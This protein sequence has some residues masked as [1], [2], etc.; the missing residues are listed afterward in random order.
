MLA[1][2]FMN[3][4]WRGCLLASMVLLSNVTAALA[5][6]PAIFKQLAGSWR[7]SG[8]LTLSDGTRD[9]ISCRGYYRLTGNGMSLA[10]LCDSPNYKIEIRSNLVGGGNGISGHWEERTFNANGELSGRAS[11]NRMRLSITGYINGSMSVSLSG[12]RQSVSISAQ[13]TGF[14]SV[15]MTLVPG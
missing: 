14:K 4:A 5:D 6:T 2:A 10:I 7:G 11:D 1:K 8:D 12:R 15:S 3:S 13:G 9:R